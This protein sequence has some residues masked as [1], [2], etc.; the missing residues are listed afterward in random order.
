MGRGGGRRWHRQDADELHGSGI[1]DDDAAAGA[2]GEETGR[3]A[4]RGPAVTAAGR[5]WEQAIP[6]VLGSRRRR[7]RRPG[8]HLHL[9]PPNPSASLLLPSSFFLLPSSSSSSFQVRRRNRSW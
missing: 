8:R 9:S 4:V 6:G 5:P 2:V 3:A 1:S 7:R